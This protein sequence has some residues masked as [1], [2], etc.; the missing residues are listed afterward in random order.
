MSEG[1]DRIWKGL[2]R[3]L[4]PELLDNAIG[5]LP[6]PDGM[7]TTSAPGSFRRRMKRPAALYDEA[8]ARSG[9]RNELTIH[10]LIDFKEARAKLRHALYDGRVVAF[11]IDDRTGL[12]EKIKQHSWGTPAGETV[13]IEGQ[14][15]IDEGPEEVCRYLF[16]PEE[17][18]VPLFTMDRTVEAADTTSKQARPPIVPTSSGESAQPEGPPQPSAQPQPQSAFTRAEL[19]AGYM[20]WVAAHEGK[21]PPTREDDLRHMKLRFPTINKDRVRNLRRDLA[22]EHWKARGRRKA[23]D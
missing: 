18:L 8:A 22:P 16:V 12:P 20:S 10:R 2:G 1:E 3:D 21:T 9:G 19:E 14:G 11:Y 23:S 15:W 13:L 7:I 5:A 17:Q 6:D 4:N